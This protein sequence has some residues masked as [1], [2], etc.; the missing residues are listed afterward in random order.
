MA[1]GNA[2]ITELNLT[3]I[4]V[5]LT[6][7]LSEIRPYDGFIQCNSPY[8]GG[9]LNN[10]YKRPLN[11]QEGHKLVRLHDG[12]LYTLF[13]KHLCKNYKEV[14]T[15]APMSIIKQKYE[16]PY[17]KEDDSKITVTF[18]NNSF[19][20][21]KLF[22]YSYD[23]IYEENTSEVELSKLYFAIAPSYSTSA[24]DFKQNTH[25]YTFTKD[26][27]TE[28]TENKHL[29]V[30]QH[31]YLLSNIPDSFTYIQ[32]DPSGIIIDTASTIKAT[33]YEADGQHNVS[34]D[35][36][37]HNTDYNYWT[38]G[39]KLR[40]PSSFNTLYYNK[41]ISGISYGN[42]VLTYDVDRLLRVTYDYVVFEDPDG[43]KWKLFVNESTYPEFEVDDNYI[44]FN[45]TD[46]M[47]TFS[48]NTDSM[49]CRSDDYNDRLLLLG[50]SGTHGQWA[51][52]WHSNAIEY[53]HKN[54]ATVYPQVS[55]DLGTSYAMF[56]DNDFTGDFD[57]SIEVFKATTSGAAAVYEASIKFT[58][59]KTY[60]TN[61]DV[62]LHGTTFAVNSDY[63][64]LYNTPMLMS[65]CDTYINEKIGKL[66]NASYVL[67]KSQRQ[68]NILGYYEFTRSEIQNIFIVQGQ[69]Y[70]VTDKFIFNLSIQN[71]TLSIE[72]AVLNKLDLEFIGAFPTYALF[73]SKLDKSLYSFT[74]DAR[75]TKIKECYRI[76]KI[77]QIY[78]DPARLTM[79]ISTNL[80][81][82]VVY[83]D[84]TFLIEDLVPKGAI[85]YDNN[86]Y[87]VGEDL[88]SL[89]YK[90]DYVVLPVK[91]QTAFYGVSQVV[92][93]V[94]DCV[95]IRL[96]KNSIEK[97]YLKL[98]AYA[99]GS[100]TAVADE[101]TFNLTD[102]MFDKATGTCL[103]RYQPAHQ[104]AT[105][106]S[107]GLES[108]NPIVSISVGHALEAIQNT[109][110]NF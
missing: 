106:F 100:V 2:Q 61:K 99:L 72:S 96:Y 101:K 1:N 40:T 89:S 87:V 91:L 20:I 4:S 77:N 5:N 105:G 56:L 80:G 43:I 57:H 41:F 44:Y 27:V 84:Q 94:N 48:F 38:R 97:G 53:N 28:V 90:A 62:T 86:A 14:T 66:E 92:K 108:T 107:I 103:I 42:S 102:N 12:N 65:I 36:V 49:F 17:V 109:K 18:M 59:R 95:Y 7:Y 74:G 3:N 31:K 63:N 32:Y 47:N 24:S 68:E 110:F 13:G 83:Q 34:T 33:Y 75:L 76:D 82:L 78:C 104:A 46:Y 81:L 19:E 85:S 6:D 88:L 30:A 45:T 60:S 54:F 64:T 10:V 22:D 15:I 52:G 8:I 58:S 25:N 70:G 39:E 73:Y 79:L 35:N 21:P 29:I 69:F 51:T 50:P 55:I 9:L 37:C 26:G 93:S 98:K 23:Y 71:S 67:A 16:D 11:L